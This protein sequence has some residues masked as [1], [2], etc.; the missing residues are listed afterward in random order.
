M[1]IIGPNFWRPG[2]LICIF[3][4][5]LLWLI[6]KTTEVWKPALFL[7]THSPS[8]F[9]PLFKDT[10]GFSNTTARQQMQGRVP[11]CPSYIA[12]NWSIPAAVWG[13]LIPSSLCSQS[14][15]HRPS[16]KGCWNQTVRGRERTDLKWSFLPISKLYG[17]FISSP[18]A[19]GREVLECL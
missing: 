3:N 9:R 10:F 18:I 11:K 16:I 2:P 13:S 7:S 1:L 4:T 6:L 17:I 5:L 15:A 14:Q 8:L 19:S 12:L